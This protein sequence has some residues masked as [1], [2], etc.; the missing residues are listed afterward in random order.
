MPVARYL[1][2]FQYRDTLGELREKRRG[3][4]ERWCF[5]L[6]VPQCHEL[7]SHDSVCLPWAISAH[8]HIHTVCPIV[9]PPWNFSSFPSYRFSSLFSFPSGVW[10]G[11]VN[12]QRGGLRTDECERGERCC[13]GHR[14]LIIFPGKAGCTVHVCAFSCFHK[15]YSSYKVYLPY[16]RQSN[17]CEDI[18]FHMQALASKLLPLSMFT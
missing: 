3:R 9:P 5:F 12:G 18:S 15:V 7:S 14:W 1:Y 10:E 6:T 8:S 17:H 13:V 16:A 11:Y 4:T 2:H